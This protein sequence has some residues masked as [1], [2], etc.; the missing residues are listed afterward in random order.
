MRLDKA[1]AT[2]LASL[3]LNFP[4]EEG[5]KEKQKNKK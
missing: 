1:G 4:S 5:G 3:S 2:F